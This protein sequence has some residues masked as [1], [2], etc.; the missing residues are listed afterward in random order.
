[1]VLAVRY[2]AT[3]SVEL[4]VPRR[5]THTYTYVLTLRQ[6]IIMY[7]VLV[8]VYVPGD[9]EWV[10][11]LVEDVDDEVVVGDGLYRRPRELPVDQDPLHFRRKRQ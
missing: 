9:E 2:T 4:I 6:F 11:E 1:M 8:V 7:S 10:V 5:Y 3:H